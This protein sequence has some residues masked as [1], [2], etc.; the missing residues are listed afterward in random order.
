[1]K[2]KNKT[3]FRIFFVG[4]LFVAVCF[5]YF[6]RMVN[7]VSN[8]PPDKIQTGTYQREEVIVAQRGE[9]YDRNGNKL[10]YNKYT[11]DLV[12]DYDAMAAT[13][14]L[15]NRDILVLLGALEA[16]NNLD[17]LEGES[18]PFDG[19]YPNYTYKTEARDGKSNM[20]YRLLKRIAENELEDES[21]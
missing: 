8:A 14:Q 1:M 4:A 20:Y 3:L 18:F 2:K 7:I 17:K 15:R 21:E 11:Y 9:I 10:V 19:T 5:V 12:F 13:Q 6:I 16:T